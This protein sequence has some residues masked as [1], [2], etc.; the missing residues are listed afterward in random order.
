[1]DS[2]SPLEQLRRSLAL[3]VGERRGTAGEQAAL[4]RAVQEAVWLAG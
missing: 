1:M 4:T 2:P 3:A